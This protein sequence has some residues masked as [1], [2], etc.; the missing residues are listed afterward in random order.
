M[1]TKKKELIGDFKNAGQV[2]CQQ[3]I[4]VHVHDFPSDA[5][6]RAVPYGIYDPRRNHGAVYVGTSAD[7][8]EFAVTAIAQWWEQ[9]GRVA[10]PQATPLL[11]LGDAG[12][13]TGYRPRLWKAPLQSRLSDGLGL[14]VTGCH[15]PTG[16]SKWNPIE[17]RVFSQI[18][19]NGA[20]QP[21]RTVETMLGYLRETTTTTGLQ[22]TATPARGSR[23]NWQEGHRCRD[24]DAEVH[25]T[26]SVHN[27]M[28]PFAHVWRALSGLERL[29]HMGK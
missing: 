20:G 6:A 22:V 5:L 16:G 2:W 24:E 9:T 4:E 18:S 8:P 13:S 1:D 3:A 12:G 7:T 15:D 29:H 14:R 25:L 21:V 17:P 23:T 27:G 19:L 10:Y 28:I 11:I 26:R